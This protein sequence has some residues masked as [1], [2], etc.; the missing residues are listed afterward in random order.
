MSTKPEYS[1]GTRFMGITRAN[2]GRRIEIIEDRGEHGFAFRDLD[3][4]GCPCG[5]RIES[6]HTADPFLYTWKVIR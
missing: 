1:P 6:A 5:P 4:F 2:L 3:E